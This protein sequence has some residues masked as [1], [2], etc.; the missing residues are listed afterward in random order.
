ML[1]MKLIILAEA[2]SATFILAPQTARQAAPQSLFLWLDKLRLLHPAGL[3]LLA[4]PH[5]L[6]DYQH[7]FWALTYDTHEIPHLKAERSYDE[8]QWLVEF[9]QSFFVMGFLDLNQV[10]SVS[11]S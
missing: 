8:G 6:A 2:F 7:V 9:A 1:H 5:F 3:N 4:K 10:N 11:W